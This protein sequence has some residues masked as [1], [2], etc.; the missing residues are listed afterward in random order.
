MQLYNAVKDKNSQISLQFGK[1]VINT[2][3]KEISNSSIKNIAVI[4]EEIPQP[5]A[6]KSKK[7]KE[8]GDKAAEDP[9]SPSAK[10]GKKK[11]KKSDA[12]DLFPPRV[13]VADL[14]CED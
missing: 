6:K 14:T 4:A 3:F 2:R 11:A 10:K 12:P 1:S 13:A 7:K 5:K 8:D 9:A